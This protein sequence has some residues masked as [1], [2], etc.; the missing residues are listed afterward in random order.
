LT[1]TFYNIW[2]KF[3]DRFIWTKDNSLDTTFCKYLIEKFQRDNRK[4]AGVVGAG[5]IDPKIK[6]STDLNISGIDDW[7]EEDRK[8][9]TILYKDLDEYLKYLKSMNC[10]EYMRPFPRRESPLDDGH[11]IQETL[12]GG[13]F[14]WHNDF[15]YGRRRLN[16][17]LT[18]IWYLN[19]IAEDG[20]TE[21][22][23]GTKIQ[24]VAGRL[25]FFPA[26]WTHVHRGYPP[27]S[28]VKYICT[29]WLSTALKK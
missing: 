4:S 21:F 12:P 28:E 2:F 24:P 17:S 18:Y 14:D 23:D 27:K 6:Q 3:M 22:Y 7:E 15:N 13:F 16:R 19:D 29:G 25:L 10:G 1:P 8:L 9:T 11:Q 5:I 20:Y 26:T